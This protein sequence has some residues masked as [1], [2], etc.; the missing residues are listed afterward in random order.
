MGPACRDRS[1][2]SAR[3]R[4]AP[5]PGKL[6]PAARVLDFSFL[7]MQDLTEVSAKQLNPTGKHRW[8]RDPL[9]WAGWAS[10]AR[11]NSLQ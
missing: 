1:G 4:S 6:A 10:L 7:Q 11:G 8:V 9:P 3:P 2:G 5:A